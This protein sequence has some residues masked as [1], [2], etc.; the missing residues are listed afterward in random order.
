MSNAAEF[1]LDIGERYI[2]V[3]DVEKKEELYVGKNFSL[4]EN[5][6]NVYISGGEKDIELTVSLVKKLVQDAGIKKKNVNIIIPDSQSYTHILEMPTLTEKEL[7]SAIKY[8]ADQFIPTP[9]DKLGLDMEILNEDRKNKKLTIL[10]IASPTQTIE[11]ITNLVESVGL[12]PEVIENETSA[13]LRLISDIYSL[14]KSKNDP[15][16]TIFI[17]FGFSSTSLYLVNQFK[18]PDG[19]FIPLPVQI[20]NFALGSSIFIRDIKA[21]F[22]MAESEI[23]KML[24]TIGFSDQSS[25][26]NVVK[27]LSSP[28]NEFLTEIE[29]FIISVKNKFGVVVNKIFLFG[30]GAKTK[31]LDKKL[32][33]SLGLEVRLLDLYPRFVKSNVIEA[34]KNDLSLFIPA[35]GGNLR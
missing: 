23:K 3:A 5:A 24:E 13:S 6:N 9:I 7:L 2:K 8:Q 11:K 18:L 34:I 20:H 26:Y 30:E 1:S 27:A 14:L 32:S 10:L 21:N 22:N 35:I 25:A 33:N 29:R 17:N 12:L 16:A 4:S 31:F 19:S 28:Y 15:A